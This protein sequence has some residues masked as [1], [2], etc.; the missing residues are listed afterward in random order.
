LNKDLV[1]LALILK[2]DFW[3]NF[4]DLFQQYLG[5]IYANMGIFYPKFSNLISEQFLNVHLAFNQL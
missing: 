2:S 4:F 3:L 5:N 1:F